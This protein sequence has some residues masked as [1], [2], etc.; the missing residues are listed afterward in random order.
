M[1]SC[2]YDLPWWWRVSLQCGAIN[3]PSVRKLSLF[4]PP[5]NDMEDSEY[6]RQDEAAAGNRYRDGLDSDFLVQGSVLI[7]QLSVDRVVP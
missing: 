2:I 1:S 4:P 7:V 3:D 5:P 6:E